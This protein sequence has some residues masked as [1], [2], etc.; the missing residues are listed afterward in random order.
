MLGRGIGCHVGITALACGAGN[1]DNA[2]P[3]GSLHARQRGTNAVEAATQVNG[4]HALPEFVAGAVQRRAVG[5]AGVIDQQLN[6]PGLLFG[7]ADGGDDGRAIGHV[8][9]QHQ[10]TCAQFFSQFLQGWCMAAQ[11][12]KARTI[13]AKAARNGRTD[14]TPSTGDQCVPA[15]KR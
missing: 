15:R 1:I 13:C 6:G 4:Q 7:L 14:A 8:R 5:L 10:R 11:Q 3:S 2:A 9:G 12:S